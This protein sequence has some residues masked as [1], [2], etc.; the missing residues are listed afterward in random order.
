[1]ADPKK[2]GWGSTVKGWFIV[3]ENAPKDAPTPIVTKGGRVPA[4]DP[5]AAADDIIRRYSGGGAGP[6]VAP[7]P[8]LRPPSLDKS[9]AKSHSGEAP[10][11]FMGGSAGG[12]ADAPAPADDGSFDFK[13]VYGKAGIKAEEIDRVDKALAMLTQLPAETPTPVKKQIVET[14]LKAFGVPVE[15]IIET[16]CAE[17]EALHGAIEAGQAAA[18]K[19][20]AE[21]DARVASLE[22]QIEDVKQVAE[23][24]R[25]EQRSLEAAARGAG[26]KVQEILEFFGVDKVGEVVR[27]SPRLTDP[28]GAK[29]KAK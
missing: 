27:E 5:D 21:S 24:R 25:A 28:T 16:A 11:D 18:A 1:M 4:S 17:I 23:Q 13:A 2:G 9:P 14:S 29:P 10:P 22:K 12:G 3:D 26:L 20:Q 7:M 6:K 15:S 8:P 19:L